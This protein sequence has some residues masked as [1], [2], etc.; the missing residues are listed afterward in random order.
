MKVPPLAKNY[1]CLT[2]E[3][4][5]RLILAASGRGDEAERDRLVRAGGRVTLSVQDH[6]PYAHA[7]DKLDMM[8]F[9]DLLEEAARYHDAFDD[10]HRADPGGDD[11]EFEAKPAKEPGAKTNEED[12]D[13]ALAV[14][15]RYFDLVA[16]SGYVL[17]AKADGWKLFCE[18]L[19]IPPFMHWEMLPGFDRLQRALALAEKVAFTAEG[20]LKWLNRIRPKGKPKLTE[21]PLVA[22]SVA[23]T[24]ENTFQQCVQWWRG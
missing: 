18:R 9:L 16:A 2:P 6:A 19:N 22:E 14:W 1:S 13:R 3:E 5:F 15:D 4:R 11:D 8:V 10:L 7:F 20:F 23:K 24:L 21:L 12:L 17:R